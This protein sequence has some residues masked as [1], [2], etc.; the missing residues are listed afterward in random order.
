MDDLKLTEKELLVLNYFIDN[1]NKSRFDEKQIESNFK[2]YPGKIETD[3]KGKIS[4]VHAKVICEKFIEIGILLENKDDS[5]KK[6]SEKNYYYI[7]SDLSAFKMIVQLILK[8]IDIKSVIKIFGSM[9]FQSRIDTKLVIKVLSDK[10]GVLRRKLDISNWDDFE[11]N[12]LYED[13]LKIPILISIPLS[14]KS[15]E[16]FDKYINEM[17]DSDIISFDIYMQR[18][19]ERLDSKKISNPFYPLELYL[20]FPVLDFYNEKDLEEHIAEIIALNKKLFEDYPNLKHNFSAVSEHY[21]KWQKQ[22]LIIPFLILIKT[23]PNALGE[24]LNGNWAPSEHN[25][26]ENDFVGPFENIMGKLLFLTIGDLSMAESYP[27]NSFIN[28]AYIRPEVVILNG[29]KENK[30]LACTYDHNLREIYFDTQFSVESYGKSSGKWKVIDRGHTYSPD[31]LKRFNT[32]I[33]MKDYPILLNYLQNTEKPVSQV[34]SNHLSTET[35][36]LIKYCDLSKNIPKA[37]ETKLK[38]EIMETLINEDWDELLDLSF[39]EISDHS[40]KELDIHLKRIKSNDGLEQLVTFSRI[41]LGQ[42]ILKDVLKNY[43]EEVDK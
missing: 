38:Y 9:F 20:N 35:K 14:K 41:A 16:S 2:T 4:R 17:P 6:K 34:I 21:A 37:L 36:N 33:T 25:F 28:N 42:S 18:K 29:D 10:G 27:E 8:N 3:L 23:S 19:L 40:K 39:D 7:S 11:A 5:P 30:L 43:V 24:F 26:C 31:I 12:K 32:F 13:R 22:N 1:D 15:S